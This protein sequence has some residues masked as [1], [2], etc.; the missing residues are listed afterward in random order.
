MSAVETID[1]AA[2]VVS[3]FFFG[4][5]SYY[6]VKAREV[7]DWVWLLYAPIGAAL[8]ILRILYDP[9]L[10]AS[11]LV[12]IGI[13]TL[14]SF[15]LFYFGLF[16][17][18]DFKAIVCLGLTLPL[19]PMSFQPLI[20]YVH[21]V[22]PLVVVIEG[23]IC[24]A[25]AAVWSGF[26]NLLSYARE[27]D[28]M[29]EGLSHESRWRKALAMTLGYRTELS[30]LQ[31]TFYLYPMEQITRDGQGAHRSLKLYVNAEADREEDVRKF[32]ESAT[33]LGYGRKVWVTPGLP[34]LLFILIGLG[35][36]LI[37]GDAIFGTVVMLA[38]R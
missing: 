37:L 25:F 15:G 34:M 6:D 31:S 38:H 19:P 3:L 8:T 22:F 36:T 21:P 10:L 5:G 4:L 32:C 23:Y 30:K 18:A 11:T 14:F 7:D 16:G 24:E 27:G 26:R 35:L 33:E 9:S 13:T 29:F 17:G 1:I 20:G 2:I 28:R 12:S